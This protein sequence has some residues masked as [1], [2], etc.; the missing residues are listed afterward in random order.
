MTASS[1][2]SVS[3]FNESFCHLFSTDCRSQADHEVLE[4]TAPLSSI[5]KDINGS[6]GLSISDGPN[7]DINGNS[8]SP[9]SGTHLQMAGNYNFDINLNFIQSVLIKQEK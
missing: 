4:K 6:N 9:N 8:I 2:K 5:D 7:S 1:A 3:L